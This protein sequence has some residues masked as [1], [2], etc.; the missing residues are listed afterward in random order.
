MSSCRH[1]LIDNKLSI[2]IEKT[3]AILF[4][5]KKR[6]KKVNPFNVKCGEIEIKD[7]NSVKYH[8][9]QL[10]DDL[11]GDFIINGIWVQKSVLYGHLS[12]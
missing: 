3:E 4:C 10:D 8:G 1:W 2:H 12:I 11:T 7:A 9:I 5:S 6:L